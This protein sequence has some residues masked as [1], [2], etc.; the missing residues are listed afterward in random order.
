MKEE[1]RKILQ[2][3]PADGWWAGYDGSTDPERNASRE[4]FLRLICWALVED[5]EGKTEVV[6]MDGD[7]DFRI[8]FSDHSSLEQYTFSPQRDP[9]HPEPPAT[10]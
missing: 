7:G 9:N 10:P 1:N 4:G 2:I 5:E 6:G 3:I 8:G